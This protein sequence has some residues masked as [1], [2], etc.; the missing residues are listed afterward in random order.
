MK[1]ESKISLLFV[2]IPLG[3]LR[4]VG[5]RRCTQCV[6]ETF[7][8]PS[9][10]TVKMATLRMGGRVAV[11]QGCPVPGDETQAAAGTVD[12]PKKLNFEAALKKA[13]V[14]PA[15][16]PVPHRAPIHCGAL[17]GSN[18][19]TK[20]ITQTR[21]RMATSM[22]ST[23]TLPKKTAKVREPDTRLFSHAIS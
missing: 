16:L 6:T 23:C 11:R 1:I 9:C 12:D 19:G 13:P 20:S 7:V 22:K 5:S 10:A 8:G 21:E 14:V 17:K 15:R 18:V 3:I 2:I 4:P